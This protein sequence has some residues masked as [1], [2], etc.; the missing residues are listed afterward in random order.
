MAHLHFI[1]TSGNFKNDK[2]IPLFVMKIDTSLPPL[3]NKKDIYHSIL[4]DTASY[5]VAG[6]FLYSR[7][8][9][10]V[11][12]ADGSLTMYCNYACSNCQK[13]ING[14]DV[15]D[16]DYEY[17]GNPSPL[18]IYNDLIDRWIFVNFYGLHQLYY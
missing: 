13:Y 10:R 2:C 7:R 5:Q 18:L 12:N 15:T 3:L 4:V 14:C 17:C 16:P 11:P 1:R 8:T 9:N 6:L